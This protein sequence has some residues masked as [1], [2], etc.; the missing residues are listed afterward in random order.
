MRISLHISGFMTILILLAGCEKEPVN[1]CRSEQLY[2]QILARG[3]GYIND[4]LIAESIVEIKQP[5]V[6]TSQCNVTIGYRHI[7]FNKQIG[8][9]YKF[10]INKDGD[11]GQFDLESHHLSLQ[12]WYSNIPDVI[13]YQQTKNGYLAIIQS[14]NNLVKNQL[15]QLYLN[16]QLIK[17]DQNRFSTITIDKKFILNNDEVFL[18]TTYQNQVT[19]LDHNYLIEIESNNQISVSPAFSY[20]ENTLQQS[21]DVIQFNGINHQWYAESN[22][23]PIY[24]YQNK[25]L[26]IIRPQ[27]PDSY[28]QNKFSKMTAEQILKKVKSDGC[29]NGDQFYSSDICQ[30]KKNRY[31]LEFKFISAKNKSRAYTQLKQMCAPYQ[32][33]DY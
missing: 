27:L 1:N 4:K 25:Q 9:N 6:N 12:K 29:L 24:S 11:I 32:F 17:L 21:G 23:F 15:Q 13:T 22:D 31:C 19:N 28:Y 16:N 10:T 33:S 3:N 5:T 7:V 30:Q 2:P 8:I 18:I 14:T 26:S 20:Q